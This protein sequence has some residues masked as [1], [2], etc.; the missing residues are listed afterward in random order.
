MQK[1]YTRD[2][3]E[4]MIK[5]LNGVFKPFV[6]FVKNNKE[7]ALCFRGN[8]SAYG[9]VIIYWHNHVIWKLSI[10]YNKQA[11]VEISANHAR[12]M[13]KWQDEIKELMKLGFRGPNNEDYDN[14]ELVVRHPIKSNKKDVKYTYDIANLT[15]EEPI[16]GGSLLNEQFVKKSF[17]ILSNMQND[18][19]SPKHTEKERPK[20]FIKEYYFERYKTKK[21]EDKNQSLYCNFQSGIEKHAQLDLFLNNHKLDSGVFVYDLEFAQP[22][23]GELFDTKTNQKVSK[24][25]NQ[26]D[27]FGI[28]FEN[29]KPK[30]ICMIEVKST[31]SAITGKSGLK[32]HL[33]GMNQ[34]RYLVREGK[35]IRLMSDRK[36]EALRI[37]NQYREIGLYGV[38]REYT[39]K[40]FLNLDEEI[41]F[42]FTNGVFK[43]DVFNNLDTVETFLDQQ[44]FM[45]D[46]VLEYGDYCKIIDSPKEPSKDNTR[47][48]ID[49]FVKRFKDK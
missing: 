44:K 21:D 18:F 41:I 25:K 13:E 32:E 38:S 42:V 36:E 19:F 3:S 48:G 27:M 39:E 11:K 8:D 24:I 40:E 33:A 47:D 49:V 29:G 30:A 37:L 7:L 14:L 34:Y 9:K 20:N 43:T 22:N 16:K 31:K 1:D 26:P 23:V 15:V 35:T 2:V 17:D 10:P 46:N 4:E 6:D 45:S 12:F 28:R 5:A